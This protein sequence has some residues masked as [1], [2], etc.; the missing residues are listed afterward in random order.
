MAMTNR[1]ARLG[2][3]AVWTFLTIGCQKPAPQARDSSATPKVAI[4]ADTSSPAALIRRYYAAINARDYDAAYALWG[5]RG[6]ASSQTRG[7]FEAGF[8]QTD[9]V[10]VT[11]SDSIRI[12]GAAG[13]QYATV[14]VIVDAVLQ[15]GT[16]QR[17]AGTYTLRRV[18]VDGATADERRWHIESAKL[19]G[20]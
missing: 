9:Q 10:K 3:T 4:V 11:F 6:A 13:S 12:E 7:Q 18:M 14:P 16:R 20:A 17:F 8:T 15:G 5:R 2:A 1:T 19:H